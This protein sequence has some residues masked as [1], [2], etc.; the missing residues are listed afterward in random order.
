MSNNIK[1]LLLAIQYRT[2]WLLPGCT[3]VASIL[4]ST[5]IENK[6]TYYI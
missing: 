5:Y 4:S 2:L 3:N 6:K 1:Y